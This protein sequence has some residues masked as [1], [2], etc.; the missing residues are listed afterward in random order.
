MEKVLATRDPNFPSHPDFA[1]FED[2]PEDM[3]G[4]LDADEKWEKAMLAYG[5]PEGKMTID[6]ATEILCN[7][8]NSAI[9]ITNQEDLERA[10]NTS[11]NDHQWAAIRVIARKIDDFDE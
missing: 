8:L 9:W 5:F 2:D 1:A 3:D 10:R 11:D 4:G 7:D 6:D